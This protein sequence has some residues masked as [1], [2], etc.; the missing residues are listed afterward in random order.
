MRGWKKDQEVLMGRHNLERLI[1]TAVRIRHAGVL[2][3][4]LAA[5]ALASFTTWSTALAQQHSPVLERDEP[6][7]GYQQPQLKGLPP[8]VARDEED[9]EGELEA[10]VKQLEQI[11]KKIC[12][13]C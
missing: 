8:D 4:P 12:P 6:V 9:T 10:I 2:A 13:G 5:A 11:Q 7:I 3:I 1:G